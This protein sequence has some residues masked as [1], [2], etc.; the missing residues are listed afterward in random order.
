MSVSE[1]FEFESPVFR[2]IVMRVPVLAIATLFCAASAHAEYTYSRDVSRIMQAKCQRCHRPN[3]IAPFPLTSYAEVSQWVHEIGH[4]VED[5]HMPP[6]KPVEGHGEFKDS[7]ALTDLERQ[8]ILAWVRAGGPEGDPADLPEP[9]P[10]AG[11]WQL[12]EP[13]RV[14][15]MPEE[16]AAPRGR[17]T[18]RCFVINTGLEA[19]A[20]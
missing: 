14:I 1:V 7:Y 19:D 6:W 8:T 9:L 12:G 18:Y 11:E 15:Q 17:D 3:D 4:A 10:D 20:Y 13:D 5:R 2:A 16:F